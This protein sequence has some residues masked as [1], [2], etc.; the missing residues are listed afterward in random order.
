MELQIQKIVYNLEIDMLVRF[1][2]YREIL[3]DEMIVS[4]LKLEVKKFS[5][6]RE[7]LRDEMVNSL[8]ANY[9]K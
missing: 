5:R 3:G 2:R 9:G 6:H 1:G 8:L 4:K 7:V